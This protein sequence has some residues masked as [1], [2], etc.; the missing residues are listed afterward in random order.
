MDINTV[1]TGYLEENCYVLIK[2]NEC[3]IVDPGDDYEKIKEVIK[4]NKILGVLITHGHSDHI[5]A[6]RHFL[7]KKS[8]KI[9]KKSSTKDLEN[10]EI[11]DFKFKVLY[12]PGHT[13]DSITFYFEDYEILVFPPPAID[14]QGFTLYLNN[15]A[16]LTSVKNMFL[17]E[18]IY[19]LEN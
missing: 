8:I 9:F 3:L 18:N 15:K 17:S 12:T 4:D 13:S 19:F 7:T 1:V 14:V 11:G 6:L 16:H 5:G 10:Y 2:N